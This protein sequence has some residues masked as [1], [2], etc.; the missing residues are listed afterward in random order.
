MDGGGGVEHAV[1]VGRGKTSLVE[2]VDFAK[3]GAEAYPRKLKLGAEEASVGLGC[4]PVATAADLASAEVGGGVLKA[5]VE[6]APY[7]KALYVAQVQVVVVHSAGAEFDAVGVVEFGVVG[8]GG[9]GPKSV[10]Y[11]GIR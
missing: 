8:V 7:D 3:Q 9:S 4:R 10:P 5:E 6:A 1:D 2:V 11:L